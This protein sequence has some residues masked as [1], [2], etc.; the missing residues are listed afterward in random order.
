MTVHLLSSNSQKTK[1]SLQDTNQTSFDVVHRM[2]IF[3]SP[4]EKCWQRPIWRQKH[5]FIGH[6]PEQPG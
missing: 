3:Y 4:E 6:F 5:L 1:L 2:Q